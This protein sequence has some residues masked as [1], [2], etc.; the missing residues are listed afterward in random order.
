MKNKILLPSILLTFAS[1]LLCGCSS[2]PKDEIDVSKKTAY[3]SSSALSLVSKGTSTKQRKMLSLDDISNVNPFEDLISQFDT[4]FDAEESTDIVIKENKDGEY[5]YTSEITIGKESNF[6]YSLN[7]NQTKEEGTITETGVLV[8]NYSPLE[9]NFSLNFEN[10][11][12]YDNENKNGSVDFKLYIDLI[13]KESTKTYVEV[14]EIIDL[15]KVNSNTFNYSLVIN[16]KEYMNYKI[17]IPESD[18][19]TLN[20]YMNNFKY[21]AERKITDNSTSIIISS[22]VSD[23]KLFSFEYIKTTDGEGNISYNIVLTTN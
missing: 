5:Q 6:K 11:I 3:A 15:E 23:T 9:F 13:N 22:Y 2:T 7:Y 12:T 21:S 1:L 18:G 20:I 19:Q 4:L 17:E 16:E 14:K 10:V 8:I